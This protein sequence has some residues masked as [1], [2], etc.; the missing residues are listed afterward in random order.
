LGPTHEQSGPERKQ[1]NAK[2]K[3]KKEGTRK[4]KQ[5]RVGSFWG[6]GGVEKKKGPSRSKTVLAQ[7]KRQKKKR[8]L[9]R[10]KFSHK[11]VK[12]GK[13]PTLISQKDKGGK[14]KRKGGLGGREEESSPTPCLFKGSLKTG[15]KK[16]QAE[17][18]NRN[19]RNGRRSE[20]KTDHREEKVQKRS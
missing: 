7:R 11:V 3:E 1:K 16:F 10:G 17:K 20:N 5:K 13:K 19:G 18:K 15:R 2:K 14:Q 8:A 12:Q 6:R 9:A 4:K